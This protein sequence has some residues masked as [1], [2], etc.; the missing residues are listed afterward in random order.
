MGNRVKKTTDEEIIS[1]Q[2]ALGTLRK[3]I[4]QDKA[5]ESVLFYL[6][7]CPWGFEK[8]IPASGE[9]PE[10]VT[11]YYYIFDQ[12][13]LV[14][15]ITDDE[16]TILESYEYSPYGELLTT[17]TITQYRF[18]SGRE[19][20]IWDPETKLYYMHARYY[21]A[22]TG[23]FLSKDS[24]RGSLTAPVS[25]N[26]YTY[27]QNDPITLAD[28]SGNSPFNT[29]LLER[30]VD[31][32]DQNLNV[33]DSCITEMANKDLGFTPITRQND[34]CYLMYTNGATSWVFITLP[35][36][37]GKVK[38]TFFSS[39]LYTVTKIISLE[40]VDEDGNIITTPWDELTINFITGISV[41]LNT[42]MNQTSLFSVYDLLAL[43]DNVSSM[44]DYF[45][46]FCKITGRDPNAHYWGEPSVAFSFM[47]HAVIGG[48]IATKMQKYN[49]NDYNRYDT[50]FGFWASFWTERSGLQISIE[51]NYSGIPKDDN[52]LS[53][54][55]LA[56][57]LKAM[58]FQETH[59]GK[60]RNSTDDWVKEGPNGQ[61]YGGIMQVPYNREPEFLIRNGSTYAKGLNFYISGEKFYN[62]FNNI[63]LGAGE[64]FCKLTA[65]P[66][67]PY[68]SKGERKAPTLAEW[69]VAVQHYGPHYDNGEPVKDYW[70]N[71]KR[72]LTEGRSIREKNGII[73]EDVQLFYQN[74]Y[75]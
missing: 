74:K 56:N 12:A 71:I 19:E 52:A 43:A 34:Q 40:I 4:H 22:V 42:I 13:G 10:V 46:D 64:L 51:R 69:L 29:G 45:D 67:Y 15:A 16:G 47:K 2:Y 75:Y 38:V 17:P 25:L 61:G 54:V 9:D 70:E 41:G 28:P 35:N 73:V 53:L 3:E 44:K 48:Y 20:C 33:G 11:P 8:V 37:R 30:K 59:V 32:A 50:I 36:N 55:D 60:G 72:I 62:I 27:C 26:R 66:G 65:Y 7:Y 18:V 57:L 31:P 68:N 58:A 5:T 6:L 23:R 39:D 49:D 24:V 14:K 63:G 21:D 1:Y